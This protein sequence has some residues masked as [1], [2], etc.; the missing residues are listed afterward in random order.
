MLVGFCI[1]SLKINRKQAFKRIVDLKNEVKNQAW[2]GLQFPPGDGSDRKLS[3]EG[4]RKSF[5]LKLMVRF[6]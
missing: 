3:N 2:G 1:F 6:G 4:Y 5:W